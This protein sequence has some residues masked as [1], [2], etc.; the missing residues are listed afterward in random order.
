MKNAIVFLFIIIGF[1]SYKNSRPEHNNIIN[2]VYD[3]NQIT[4]DAKQFRFF[5]ETATKQ[6]TIPE[7]Y[8]ILSISEEHRIDK[9]DDRFIELFFW[10]L[11]EKYQGDWRA[12]LPQKIHGTD[13]D[14]HT[15]RYP[16]SNNTIPM[17][18][19]SD[20]YIYD[21][22]NDTFTKL[23]WNIYSGLYSDGTT[24][25][26]L[27]P[28]WSIGVIR[29]TSFDF[30]DKN[31][32]VMYNNEKTFEY[33]LSEFSD[34]V[35]DNEYMRETIL[36]VNQSMN[37]LITRHGINLDNPRSEINSIGYGKI[38]VFEYLVRR[39][40]QYFNVNIYDEL[41]TAKEQRAEIYNDGFYVYNENLLVLFD[42]TSNK[43]TKYMFDK[44]L[45]RD[46]IEIE[47]VRYGRDFDI[48]I[49]STIN[50][51]YLRNYLWYADWRGI[52]GDER[53]MT[54]RWYKFDF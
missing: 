9:P 52:K 16:Y 8:R 29:H 19:N 36:S 30:I 22:E 38:S 24:F 13:Y 51:I 6:L 31:H 5:N 34:T 15:L 12:K 32:Q 3:E 37:N 48:Y 25:M 14:C 44:I 28:E 17:R 53:I 26:M 39:L 43:V 7:G 46:F 10:K 33:L 2:N 40:D 18:A 35:F 42:I 27:S 47:N 41:K 1:I 54:D 20:C 49:D 21:I 23:E 45:I 4:K 11:P 50:N